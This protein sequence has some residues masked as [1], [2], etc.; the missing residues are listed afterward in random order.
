MTEAVPLGWLYLPVAFALG[1]LHALEP[2]H[3]KSLASAY[4]VTGK[5][6]WKDAVVLGVATTFSH[7]AVVLLLAAASLSLKR[8][9]SQ[10]DL[11][12]GMALTGAGILI[13]MGA[14]VAGRSALDLRHGHSHGHTHAHSHGHGEGGT[15]PAGGFWGVALIGL[16]NGALPCPGA[17]AALL[18]ALSLGQ[19]A[20]G[21]VTVLTY[22]LGL[23]TALAT[24]GIL[25]VEAG[26]R[27]RAWLPSDRAMLWLPLASGLLIF[28]TG[29]WLLSSS[30]R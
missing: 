12:H 21:F 19:T 22:S 18:V 5:H 27:V 20:L 24:M 28:G 15:V 17:L 26:R 30:W 8:Y 13:V 29:F 4:L 7:T 2:G 3:G 14:W 1:A 6:D 23:A 16:S 9:F 11:E 10:G 25:V